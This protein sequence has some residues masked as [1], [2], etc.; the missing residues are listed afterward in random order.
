MGYL[1]PR[2]EEYALSRWRMV[3]YYVALIVIGVA[4]LTLDA[5]GA[6][7]FGAG[8]A[9]TSTAG[10]VWRV[11]RMPHPES[12]AIVALV[13]LSAGPVSFSHLD[14]YKR[15]VVEW[16]DLGYRGRDEG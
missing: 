11:R 4:S 3:T 15:Q 13:I 6:V 5:V 14:V 12:W 8:Y 9:V 1:H 16:V 10:L 2:T 7:A